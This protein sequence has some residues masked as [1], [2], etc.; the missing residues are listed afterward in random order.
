VAAFVVVPVDGPSEAGEGTDT[1]AVLFETAESDLVSPH[2]GRPEVRELADDAT[3]RFEAIADAAEQVYQSVAQR[4]RPDRME[5][6]LS[7]GLSGE[8]GWFV[9]K[10]S[11]TGGLK[12]KL[13]WD[14]K[15][16]PSPE[17]EDLGAEVLAENASPADSSAS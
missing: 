7:V 4:L 2:G 11:A 17:T 5:L 9:A 6:E 1:T 13:S 16:P 14:A 10:S 8:V 3:G 12:L 15:T